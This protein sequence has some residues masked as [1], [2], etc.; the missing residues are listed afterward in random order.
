M[1][2]KRKKR[3]LH[4][5]RVKVINFMVRVF[6]IIKKL[7]IINYEHRLNLQMQSF[8]TKKR[9]SY[10]LEEGS[11]HMKCIIKQTAFYGQKN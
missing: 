5:K 8:E 1:Q 9:M 2:P 3:K 6:I 7:Y 11:K 4:I 10:H